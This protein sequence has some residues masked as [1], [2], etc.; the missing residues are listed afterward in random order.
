MQLQ[1]EN[2]NNIIIII[3]RVRAR[4]ELPVYSVSRQ[5]RHAKE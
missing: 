1:R 2:A 5:H 3:I 4:G